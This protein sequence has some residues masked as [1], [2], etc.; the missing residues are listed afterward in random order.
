MISSKC[1]SA[2]CYSYAICVTRII[3]LFKLKVEFN[4]VVGNAHVQPNEMILSLM[5]EI[6]GVCW[7]LDDGG[8]AFEIK[9]RWIRKI[10][11]EIILWTRA[12]GGRMPTDF[13]GVKTYL[14]VSFRLLTLV[15]FIHPRASFSPSNTCLTDYL[16]LVA[17]AFFWWETREIERFE[18]GWRF[19]FGSTRFQVSLVGRLHALIVLGFEVVMGRGDLVEEECIWAFLLWSCL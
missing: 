8:G 6:A 9:W 13:G 12:L 19:E 11:L 14:K 7:C 2:L 18:S 3:E 4:T 10:N 16:H 1:H 5:L 15:S 17:F